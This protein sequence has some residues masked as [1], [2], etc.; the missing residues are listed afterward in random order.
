M[1]GELDRTD[2]ESRERFL[3]AMS[4]ID[5]QRAR[6]RRGRDTSTPEPTDTEEPVVNLDEPMPELDEPAPQ[7]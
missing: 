5:M 2:A 7:A 3:S 4:P 6:N 1:V